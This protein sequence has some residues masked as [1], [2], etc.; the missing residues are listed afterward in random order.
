MQKNFTKGSTEREMFKEFWDMCQRYWEPEN[1]DEYWKSVSE[2][3]DEFVQK[4]GHLHSMVYH[5]S[6]AFI[7]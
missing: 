5:L 1:N 7:C 2:A 6:V 4:Y 3:A